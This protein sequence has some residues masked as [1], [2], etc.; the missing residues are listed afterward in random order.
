MK[1]DLNMGSMLKNRKDIAIYFV[2]LKNSF[3]LPFSF[4]EDVVS[5]GATSPIHVVVFS[6]IYHLSG[7]FWLISLKIFYFLF[8]YFG[9]IFLAKTFDLKDSK[10]TEL[11]IGFFCNYIFFN[12]QYSTSEFINSCF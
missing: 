2:F 11:R 9:I 12:N 4:Q 8:F 5:F 10:K 6:F 3:D 7:E 1:I